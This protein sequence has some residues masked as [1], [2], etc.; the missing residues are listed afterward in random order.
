MNADGSD[1]RQL[2]H[3][4]SNYRPAVSASG[5]YI[6]FHSGRAGRANI[7]RMDLD[8]GN[9]KQLTNGKTNLF[10]DVSPDGHWVVYA[11]MNSG[12]L[13]LWKVSID[14]GDPVQLTGIVTNM[15]AIS[16][17]GKHVASFY[18]D[19][20]VNDSHGVMIL[21]FAGGQPA[22]RFNILADSI[23]GFVLRWSPDGRALLHLR[24]DLLNVWS[25]PVDGGKPSQLTKFQ[26][27]QIF[28]FA[29]SHDGKWLAVARGR[30]AEDV[31]LISDLR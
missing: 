24:E 3:E 1:Q 10:P 14:G 27:D 30:V 11:S 6:V 13:T 18:W 8:G 12:K 5:R 25:Q 15:P 23:N 2:T 16:P 19:E 7:W 9:L 31:V 29:W 26:G 21:P 17:D 4:G 28:N 22:K 20:N